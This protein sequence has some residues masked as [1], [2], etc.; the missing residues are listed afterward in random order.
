MAPQKKVSS[1]AKTRSSSS[2]VSLKKVKGENFYRN[3]K[4][5]GRLKML[6]GGKAVRD[7][8]GKVIQ[9]AA[10]QKGEDETK[11]GRV[12]P[13]RRWFGNTRVISQKALDHF[14]TSLAGKQHD[15]YSVLLRRNKLP[16]ALLDDAA[17]PNTR[18]RSHIV[19][20]EPFEQTFGPKAQRK[21]PRIEVGTFEELSKISSANVDEAEEKADAAATDADASTSAVEFPVYS[22]IIEPIYAKG[23][24]R[25]IYGE[26]YKVIDSSDVILHI[27]D[28]RD[29]MGTLCESVLEF[30]RKEKA[31]KQ[32]VLVINKCDLVPNWVTAR[33]IQHLTPRYPTVAFHASPNHSFGKGSLIQLLRQFSQLHSDK[34]QISV[35]FV[36]YPNVGKSSVINT[37]K[38]GK[39]C[40]VAPVPGETK[41]WQYITLTKRIYLIDCPGIVP[42][43]AKDSQT[44]TVLKGVV[45][46]EALATPS[47]HIPALME[48]VKPIYLSRTYGI[49]LPNPDDPSECWVPDMFLDKLARMKGRLLKGGEPDLDSVAKILL[50]DWVRGRIPYFVPPPERPESLNKTEAKAASRKAAD[51]KGKGK[52][53]DKE[54]G[55]HAIGVKQNLGSIMQKNTFVGEDVKSLEEIGLDADKDESHSEE[56]SSEGEEEVDEAQ[57]AEEGEELAWND[58]FPGDAPGDEEAPTVFSKGDDGE[59]AEVSDAEASNEDAQ[60]ESRMKTN[61][62]KPTNFYTKTNV[63]NKNRQK[64]QVMKSL[65]KSAG[66]EGRR[67][68]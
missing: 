55:G 44:S 66:R 4:Q 40:N 22:D 35:G 18:K 16:M 23:T 13:D 57:P 42:T 25:R 32:V 52:A 53:L 38:S 24:S 26:L 28:A 29:P 31:H 50:S 8:D 33:Y 9:A 39:V 37:L 5:I 68:R 2:G 61:K 21:K 10:F 59:S 12:Q 14:R 41:V 34:K 11:P 62:R 45:R 7:K 47:E 1:D 20:T 65:Q 48:R 54:E 27:L 49:D 46:V 56:G 67:K 17:N 63:K 43:S 36:G 51:A 60:K 58:V 3:A 6:N 15:P 19:D 30:I 64:A